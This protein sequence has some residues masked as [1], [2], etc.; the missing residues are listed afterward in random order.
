MYNFG[1]PSAF[2]AYIDQI[3]RVG[4]TFLFD[5]DDT[6][7]PYRPLLQGKRAFVIVSSGDAGYEAG[8]PHES[9][10]H[11][12]PYLRTVFGFIGI[13]DVRFVHVGNDEF[14]GDKLAASLRGAREE[15]EWLA[16]VA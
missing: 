6:E 2:K 8:G 14:G 10:N 11:V 13:V 7:Q 12:D 15:L 3:V 4:R 1:V 16:V 5:P 9:L